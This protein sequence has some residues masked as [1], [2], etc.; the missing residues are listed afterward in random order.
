MQR[1]H[2]ARN[3]VLSLYKMSIPE[4][5]SKLS[6]DE[7][8]DRLKGCIFGA[9]LG[10][11]VGLATEFLS[12]SKARELYG[13]GPISFGS[14]KGYEFHR[15]YHRRRWDDGDWT[16]DTDQQLLIIDSLIATN[17]LFN[18]RDFAHRL[19]KWVNKGYPELNNKPPFGIGKTV[20]TVLSHSKFEAK[21]HRASWEVWVRFNRNM[22]A[23]GAL[24]RTAVLGAPFFWDE[25]QV[26]KQTLQATKVTHADPRCCVSSLIVTNLISRLLKDNTQDILPDL[27]DETK[28]EILKWTQS[29][30]PDNQSDLDI[31]SE[32]P[33]S[34]IKSRHVKKKSIIGKIINKVSSKG[35]NSETNYI[36][37]RNSDKL[38]QNNPREVVKIPENPPPGI[39][40]FG[41]DPVMSAF[42]R[43]VVERY[44]FITN[45]VSVEQQPEKSLTNFQVDI[46]E[47]ALL[48][49]CF[50]DNLASLELDEGSSIGY[51][52]KC[53]GSAL[54]CFTRNLNQQPSEGEAFKTII[55]ELTLEAGD[56]DTNGA[57]AGAL[58]GARIGYEKLPKSW[59]DGLKFKSWLEDRVNSL[60][61]VV[62][63]KEDWVEVDD[64]YKSIDVSQGLKKK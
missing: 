48:K 59:V 42:V 63:G 24:M 14:D 1:N 29:G 31:D 37:R 57:V 40:T 2:N 56:S 51:V 16:D 47:E 45:S 54:Y 5:A 11:A 53:L 49:Y 28:K 50:P 9:A 13:I 26:I 46:G 17:G 60:W 44:K 15:D 25:K 12:K 43:S 41:A 22:A 36:I 32:D 27:D 62:S 33:P 19:S 35:N 3:Y 18:S 61:T 52:Y 7:I 34:V 8:Y 23:N 21:P 6:P 38:K 30:N 64:S 58:L 4:N 39:D 55:T 10:D 20:G